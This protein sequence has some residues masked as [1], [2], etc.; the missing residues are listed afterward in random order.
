M[1]DD[2]LAPIVYTWAII[3]FHG[4]ASNNKPLLAAVQNPNTKHLPM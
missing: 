1:T 2:P 4:A 3:W